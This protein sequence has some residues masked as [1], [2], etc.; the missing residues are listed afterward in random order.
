MSPLW[1]E[2]KLLSQ[3]RLVLAFQAVNVLLEYLEFGRTT[4]VHTHE[5]WLVK[6]NVRF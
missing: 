4:S 5:V 1:Q 3:T 6:L 2:S